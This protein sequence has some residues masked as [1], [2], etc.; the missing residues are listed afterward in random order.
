MSDYS[1]NT[2]QFWLFSLAIKGSLE[3]TLTRERFL[4]L[5]FEQNEVYRI[6][7]THHQKD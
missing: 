5:D 2:I 6:Y 4:R 3:Y 7:E 1:Q